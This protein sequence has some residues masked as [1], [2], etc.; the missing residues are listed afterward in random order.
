MVRQKYLDITS[1]EK[2]MIKSDFDNRYCEDKNNLCIRNENYIY[3]IVNSISF[4]LTFFE[5]H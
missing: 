3:Q 5:G 2:T 1:Y 4:L